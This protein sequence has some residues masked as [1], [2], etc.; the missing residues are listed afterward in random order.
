MPVAR[1]SGTSTHSS[2]VPQALPLTDCCA[3]E[4]GTWPSPA[5]RPR[6]QGQPRLTQALNHS[7]PS[8]GATTGH[9]EDH[10]GP[11]PLRAWRP[12]LGNVM[13]A[14]ADAQ[15]LQLLSAD[16]VLC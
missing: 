3:H 16:G 1:L 9:T 6:V 10:A 12:H 8:A 15:A 4:V 13:A 2:A 14:A 11:S 7:L 5:Q